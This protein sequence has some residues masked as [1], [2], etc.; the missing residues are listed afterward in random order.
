MVLINGAEAAVDDPIVVG[1]RVGLRIDSVGTGI[2]SASVYARR[3][4]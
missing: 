3:V 1:D 2:L 4:G